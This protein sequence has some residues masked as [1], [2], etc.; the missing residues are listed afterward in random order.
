[1]IKVSMDYRYKVK[2]IERETTGIRVA[3]KA[4]DSAVVLITEGYVD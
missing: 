4:P 3:V 1:M 2:G